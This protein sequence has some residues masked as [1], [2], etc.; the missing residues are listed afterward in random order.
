MAASGRTRQGNG[1]MT[2]WREPNHPAIIVTRTL[3]I[4]ILGITCSS[5]GEKAGDRWYQEQI[6]RY[7]QAVTLS[8]QERIPIF[9]QMMHLGHGEPKSMLEGEHLEIYKLNQKALLAI[10]GHAEYFGDQLWRSYAAYKA[11]VIER[12]DYGPMHSYRSTRP[13]VMRILENLPSAET[14]RVLGEMLSEEWSDPSKTKE[15]GEQFLGSLAMNAKSRLNKLPI[16]NKPIASGPQSLRAW[17]DWYAQIKEGRR[18]FRFEGDPQEYSLS[19]PVR[20]APL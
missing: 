3:L 6:Q 9:G 5:A 14:V 11:G 7:K 12:N 4:G 20:E 2:L 18:T 13:E 19:G 17:Q 1:F 8:D 16:V 15:D 10:P